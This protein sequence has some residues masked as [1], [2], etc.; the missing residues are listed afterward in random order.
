MSPAAVFSLSEPDA[1]VSPI[2]AAASPDSSWE[3]EEANS[4]EMLSM[5][6]YV[7]FNHQENEIRAKKIWN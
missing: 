7:Q 4:T 5:E 1:V 2:T 3:G 6:H